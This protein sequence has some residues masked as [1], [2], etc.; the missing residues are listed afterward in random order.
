MTVGWFKNVL[1]N[2]KY[3]QP[4][5][6]F[7]GF[8]YHG[9]RYTCPICEGRFR[10]FLPFGRSRRPNAECPR[11]G[12][13][14]RHRLLWLF[15]KN[16]TNFFSEHLKVLHFG[17][18]YTLLTRLRRVPDINY[19]SADLFSPIA[20]VTLDITQID[21]DDDSFDVVL[22]I[23]VLEHVMDDLK[24]MRELHRILRPGGWAII[25]S[26]VETER[27]K[28]FEDP[29]IINPVARESAFGQRDHVRI[30]GRDYKDRLEQAGFRVSIDPYVKSLEE[31]LVTE[32]GLTA[33]EDIYYCTKRKTVSNG[34][35]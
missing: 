20:S 19:V 8:W 30:Y 15:L 25:Q 17:P 11:C 22:C 7:R 2:P 24:A 29:A 3:K 9:D 16:R 1:R 26:P 21:A 32:Y 14:E 35:E 31:A 28:T 13:L 5:Y 12:S 6:W 27:A 4:Y 18:E 33:D 34:G 23:H 10:T